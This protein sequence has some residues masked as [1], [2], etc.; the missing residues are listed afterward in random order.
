[1]IQT[2]KVL[3]TVTSYLIQYNYENNILLFEVQIT[4]KEYYD[5]VS[6]I[7]KKTNTSGNI[8]EKSIKK[9]KKTF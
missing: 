1:M 3:E 5:Y 8:S 4:Y 9:L 7:I 6:R 2:L